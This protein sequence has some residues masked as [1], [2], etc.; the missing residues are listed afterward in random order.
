MSKLV[1]ATPLS[2][3]R[4]NPSPA[5]DR[6]SKVTSGSIAVIDDVD[7]DKDVVLDGDD[8]A[9]AICSG[10]PSTICVYGAG[11]DVALVA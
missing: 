11:D 5:G 1:S 10:S 4:Q 9:A 3:G 6:T 2:T 7:D 8:G